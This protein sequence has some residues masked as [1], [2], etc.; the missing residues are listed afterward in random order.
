MGFVPIEHLKTVEGD[1]GP[2]MV[3]EE[4]DPKLRRFGEVQERSGVV[5]L[6]GLLG[7]SKVIEEERQGPT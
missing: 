7:T 6:R 3:V 4:W 5:G 2:W 1:K